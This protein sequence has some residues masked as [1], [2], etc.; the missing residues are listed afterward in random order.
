MSETTKIQAE[1]L[2]EMGLPPEDHGLQTLLK[3]LCAERLK[4]LEGMMHDEIDVI[5]GRQERIRWLNNILRAI[6]N[7]TDDKKGTL[8]FSADSDLQ[9]LL[10]QA[11]E[12][13]VKADTLEKQANELDETIKQLESDPSASNE[14][15]Q[16]LKAKQKLLREEVS[17]IRDTVKA[18]TFPPGKHQFTKSERERLVDNLRTAHED[19]SALNQQ[20]MQTMNRLNNE[21]HETLLL[22]KMIAKNIHE[23]LVNKARAIAR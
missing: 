11:K 10:D 13:T 2:Q 18:V 14:Q 19:L 20:Q 3:L 15:I 5:K 4:L 1:T 7:S 6:N 8:E 17:E 16:A 22:A 12:W 21:R 9:K 23:D